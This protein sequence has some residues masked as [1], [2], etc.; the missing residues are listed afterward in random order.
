MFVCS[1]ACSAFSLNNSMHVPMTGI[2]SVKRD[3]ME[4]VV[5][6]TSSIVRTKK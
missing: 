4:T 3:L 5:P 1:I 6:C 2:V